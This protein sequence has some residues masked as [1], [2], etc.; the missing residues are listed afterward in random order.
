MN[1]K[2][3]P[4]SAEIAR[5]ID[6]SI[7]ALAELGNEIDKFAEDQVLPN[8]QANYDA[9]LARAIAELESEGSK[10]TGLKEK[11]KGRV[12]TATRELKYAE[13]QKWAIDKKLEL[14]RSIISAR[15]AQLNV[16]DI[17]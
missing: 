7:R 1:P 9:L 16:Q 4:D 15:K 8:A 5:K 6:N 10:S 14:H 13:I 17:V 2:A 12:K 3:R 11:A